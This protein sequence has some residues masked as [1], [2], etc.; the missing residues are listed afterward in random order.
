MPAPSSTD[1]ATAWSPGSRT[2]NTVTGPGPEA[3]RSVMCS[4]YART[5][6]LLRRRGKP[7]A[8]SWELE[9]GNWKL[10]AGSRKLEAGSWELEAGNWK[11]GSRKLDAQLPAPRSRVTAS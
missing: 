11:L 1:S 2:V 3:S 4:V 6:D 10:G 8:G 9:A 7:E 5:G